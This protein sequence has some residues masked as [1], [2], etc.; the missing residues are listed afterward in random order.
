MS[1]PVVRLLLTELELYVQNRVDEGVL[2]SDEAATTL[3][4]LQK[5]FKLIE[6]RKSEG[7]EGEESDE[8][9]IRR[10]CL[11]TAYRC[12]ATSIGTL[13]GQHRETRKTGI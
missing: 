12:L 5:V 9:E 4:S 11:L 2:I 6:S 7:Q 10:Q 3:A 13:L 8:D 1:L